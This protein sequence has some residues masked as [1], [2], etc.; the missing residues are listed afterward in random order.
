MREVAG[1]TQRQLADRLGREP[2]FIWRIEH[3]ERRL[4]VVEFIRYTKACGLPEAAWKVPRELMALD[5]PKS[6]RRPLSRPRRS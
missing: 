1:L 6:K 3:G 5:V 2:S 4:D